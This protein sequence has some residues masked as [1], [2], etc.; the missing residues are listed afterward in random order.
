MNNLDLYQQMHKKGAF[1]GFSVER[2]LRDIGDLVEKTSAKKLIDVG[3]GK[4]YAYL[5]NE[6]HSAWGVD[7]P[8]F[9]D[10]AVPSFNNQPTEI[11]DG[12]IC[13]DVLEHLEESD[14]DEVLRQ[15]YAWTVPDHGFIFISVC[16]RPAKK[17]LPDGRNSHLTVRPS[18]WWDD[19]IRAA[20]G[21]KGDNFHVLIVYSP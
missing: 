11:F 10:P 18:E 13:S 3:C 17:L 15:L 16:C 21:S 20:L 12:A 2:Y 1:S 8:F 14:I 5:L 9:Y 19:K 7:L 6:L 4:A